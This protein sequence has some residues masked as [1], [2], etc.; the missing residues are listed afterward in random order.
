LGTAFNDF[1]N[2]FNNHQR[3][4]GL[5]YQSDFILPNAHFISAGIDYDQERAVFDSGFAGQNR[6]PAERR[7]I[8]A[9][10]QDQFSYGPRMFITAGFRVE[11][12]R[13]D[14]P[15]NFAKLLVELKS[16]PC[17]DMVGFGTEFVPKIA[18]IYVL[19]PSGIQS[20]RGPTRLKA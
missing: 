8:G 3:R 19:R 16:A 17:S 11:N 7:N 2:F 4:R 13:A 12:N 18:A 5:R 20:R 6:I 10:I 1:A 14:V 9:F 15:A